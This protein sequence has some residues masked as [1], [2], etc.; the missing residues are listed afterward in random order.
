VKT[1]SLQVLHCSDTHLDESFSISNLA[2]AIQRREDLNSNSFALVIPT[3]RSES[4]ICGLSHFRLL[5]KLSPKKLLEALKRR[6][7]CALFG[8]VYVLVNKYSGGQ[9]LFSRKTSTN[10]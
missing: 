1:I 5:N 4:P 9:L 3:T 6:W 10:S 2:K 7:G 8:F